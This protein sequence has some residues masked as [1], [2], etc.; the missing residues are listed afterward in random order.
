MDTMPII[1]AALEARSSLSGYTRLYEAARKEQ[2]AAHNND[3][4]QTY[5]DLQEEVSRLAGRMEF[6]R[7]ELF[8]C[9]E[10]FIRITGRSYAA[11][12]SAVDARE[13]WLHGE[14]H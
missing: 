14:A 3:D 13:R 5:S 7:Q 11:F 12:V 1:D 8:R 9:E 6:F 4:F 10:E 2:I